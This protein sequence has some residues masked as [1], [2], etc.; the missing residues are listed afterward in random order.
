M[1]EQQKKGIHSEGRRGN[2]QASRCFLSFCK[3][4]SSQKL[5][6][7]IREVSFQGSLFESWGPEFLKQA[8]YMGTLLSH[9]WCMYMPNQVTGTHNKS[10]VYLT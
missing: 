8:S 2:I 9:D 4:C 10:Y 6:E 1:Q 3:G 7:Q 5:Q